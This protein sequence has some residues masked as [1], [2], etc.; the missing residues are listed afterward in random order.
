M[1]K[2]LTISLLITLF[3][4]EKEKTQELEYKEVSKTLGGEGIK[5]LEIDSCEYVLHS[6]DFGYSICHKGN[7]KFCTR[8]NNNE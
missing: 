2:L 6:V 7:C 4:C 3:S 1:S 5:I 8:R